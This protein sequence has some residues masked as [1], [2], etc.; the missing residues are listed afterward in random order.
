MNSR[1][2][3]LETHKLE[4]ISKVLNYPFN[5][6]LDELN[7]I[8]IQG[9]QDYLKQHPKWW[10]E[11]GAT[12]DQ[13]ELNVGKMFGTLVVE[14]SNHQLYCLW[15]VSGKIPE[16]NQTPQ[17]VPP[18]VD[19]HTQESFYKEGEAKTLSLSQQIQELLNSTLPDQLE[20]Q[21]SDL[22][23]E[24][25]Q[26]F[27]ELKDQQTNNKALRKQRRQNDLSTSEIIALNLESKAEKEALKSLKKDYQ[28]TL[29]DLQ[30]KLESHQQA[31]KD[32]KVQRKEHSQSLQNQIFQQYQLLNAL[33][34]RKN[35]IEAFKLETNPNPPSG[36]GDCCAP[37]LLQYAYEN[38]LKPIRL[39]EFWWGPS[40][41]SE[42]RIQGQIYPACKGKCYPI[43]QHMLQ[44]LEVAPNPM[45]QRQAQ[46]QDI[47]VLYED[48]F[49]MAINK[50]VDLFS[51]PGKEI[52]DSVYSRLKHQYPHWQGSI[53]L[54]R[55][56]LATSGII[57]CA[58]DPQSY[59]KLQQQFIKRNIKKKYIA[60][61][62]ADLQETRGEI[63]LPLIV[64]W[65]NRPLQ[66]VCQDTGKQAHTQWEKIETLTNPKNDSEV[67]TRVAF[68]PITGRTHQLRVHSAHF[69]GLG[70]P[71]VGDRLYGKP[72]DRLMLH[73]TMIQFNH[74]HSNERITIESIP[75]F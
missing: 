71:I 23:K 33:G 51:S 10:Q 13:G 75:D 65:E 7:S 48:E 20:N 54:H 34:Q 6:D 35:P 30:Q 45:H 31:I 26:Q 61:I 38:Q 17:F 36:T 3:T 52:E 68:Y 42:V 58:K 8:A 15:A 50:P 12:R 25:D 46:S 11:F 47:E 18:I 27:S 73:A 2:H 43:L 69:E 72:N 60:L 40:P 57:L 59:N 56:D 29:A 62:S 19:L 41:Q 37:K 70:A 53:I 55:L 16:N 9:L 4:P 39:A 49:I 32:L 67:W 24:F 22:S 66:K 63:K 64:D 21:K 44:G 5:Y 1:L 28:T 14:D 74:P